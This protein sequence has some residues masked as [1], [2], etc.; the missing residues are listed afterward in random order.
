MLHSWCVANYQIRYSIKKTM[1]Q[2]R[3]QKTID[4]FSVM[5]SFVCL[6]HCLA[7][8]LL[9]TLIPVLA[10]DWISESMFHG[11]MLLLVIPSS[12]LA[13]LMARKSKPQRWVWW[14]GA[15]GLT[16]M[17]LVAFWGHDLIGPQGERWLTVL[18]GVLVATAHLFNFRHRQ[19]KF[20]CNH[21]PA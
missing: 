15:I 7:L 12:L 8:P 4:L 11:L 10:I 17:I 2:L 5:L 9:V 19:K 18:G 6:I 16:I 1:F 14:T 20:C 3:L 13:F 21:S